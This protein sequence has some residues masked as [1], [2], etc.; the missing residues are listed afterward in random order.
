MKDA[1]KNAPRLRRRVRE[2][3]WIIWRY[4]DE[5]NVERV[6]QIIR[7]YDPDIDGIYLCCVRSTDENPLVRHVY[8][9]EIEA[10]G[11]SPLE[12]LAFAE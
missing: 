5:P 9:Y 7:A 10:F 6:G 2:G 3:D 1:M 4:E 8:S 11:A 12:I